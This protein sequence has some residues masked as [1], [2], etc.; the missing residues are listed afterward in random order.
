MDEQ[1]RMLGSEHDAQLEREARK[2]QRADEAR[3][4]RP[5]RADKA[6]AS[7]RGEATGLP[8]GR[9]I[10]FLLRAARAEG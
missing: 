7:R 6:D 1:Y 5:A 4:S 10:A 9:I 2:W 3:R 8:R